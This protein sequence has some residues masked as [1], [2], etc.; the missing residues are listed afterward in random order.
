LL[1]QRGDV[2]DLKQKME[3]VITEAGL[4]QKMREN[5]SP[6]KSVKEEC[7]ELLEVYK[8]LSQQE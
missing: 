7:N 4:L 3:R 2:L 1:F 5:I 8:K 6:V